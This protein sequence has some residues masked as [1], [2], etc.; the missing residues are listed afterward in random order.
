V[1]MCQGQRGILEF[2]FKTP[3]QYLFRSIYSQAADKGFIGA[4]QAV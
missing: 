1:M 4:F 3:G 2:S